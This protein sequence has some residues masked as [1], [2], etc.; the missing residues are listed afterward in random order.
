MIEE[1]NLTMPMCNFPTRWQAVLYRLAGM[2]P[3]ERIAMVLKTD[4][5]TLVLEAKRLGIDDVKYDPKWESQG[6][7]TI[8]RSMWFLLPTEQITELIMCSEEE[9]FFTL[10]DEDFF[11][12]KL[13]CHKP[14]CPAVYYSPLTDS[15]IKDTSTEAKSSS[16][17]ICS[18][19]T[20]LKL[21][22]S[23]FTTRS[24]VRSFQAS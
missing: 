13:G 22:R 21:V 7:Q 16:S 23:R 19:V 17:V 1:R 4:E 9:L 5:A 8:I 10:R 14:T 24:S 18:L 6:Y 11:I 15:E 12:V 3:M 20:Y 2:I